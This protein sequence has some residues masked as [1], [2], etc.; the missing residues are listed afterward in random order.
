LN[1]GFP[2]VSE[3]G[4]MLFKLGTIYIFVS[5]SPES[6][7]GRGLESAQRRKSERGL[8]RFMLFRFTREFA[9]DLNF[10]S[11]HVIRHSG[12]TNIA[13]LCILNTI[14]EHRMLN[15]DIA[16]DDF[17]IIYI[18]P[19][20]ALATE[21]TASFGKRLATIGLQVRELTGDT[22]LSKKEISE[23][24]MLI[25]TPEKW[26]VVTRKGSSDNS[27]TSLVRLL[28]IDEVHLLH[29]DRGPVIETIV[30]RTLRQ[31]EMS[32]TG[33]RI[34]GLSAT[35]PNYVDVA[36]F[37]RVNPYK[38]L[39]F[40]DGR[41]RPVPLTQKFIGVK[42]VGGVREVQE[43]MNEVC[44][45]EVLSYVKKGHQVLV[46]VH[47]R[48]A[49]VNLAQAFRDR[50]A[51]LGHLE[52][53]LPKTTG[54]RG[55]VQASR[56]HKLFELFRFGFGVHHAGLIRHDRLLMEK[57]F[58][59]G[60]TTVLFCTATLAWGVNLPAH[61]V[62]IRGTDVFDAEKGQFADLGV[63]DV[64]Q[65]FGRAGRPQFEDEGH[66]IIITTQNKL[67]KYL[68]MLIRQAPIESQFFKRIHDN[69]N[70]EIALGLSFECCCP[71]HDKEYVR[72][73]IKKRSFQIFLEQKFFLTILLSLSI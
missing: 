17:K 37:L 43:T 72:K 6:C 28:I 4:P 63:L 41:F 65:I 9:F 26:D 61:A 14:H 55:Y 42:K 56:N 40:F 54:T 34:V 62:V 13:M 50:A 12:K 39:F 8:H 58:H 47:A 48:N 66:G 71:L 64:Q 11:K 60:H 32:Q 35:L 27:L 1:L 19:M 22:T 25:L 31:V 68:A 44:Y 59:Q 69:L 33:I 7:L 46:F 24:Q 3:I 10:T 49:T 67:D 73:K 36:R 29:D 30:A 5:F 2:R 23:T 18:A 70:A 53:F 51:K 57:V 21:M 20:K 38:G 15:G 52:M 16:K 45:D